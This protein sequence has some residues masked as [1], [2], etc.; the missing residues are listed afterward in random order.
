MGHHTLPTSLLPNTAPP[1][2]AR[3]LFVNIEQ[4][5]QALELERALFVPTRLAFALGELVGLG[6]RFPRCGRAL[7]LRAVVVGRRP[8]RSRGLLSAGVMLRL[9]DPDPDVLALVRQIA[10][11]HVVD[12]QGRLQE[13]VRLP[14]RVYYASREEA[15]DDLADLL[16]GN[17]AALDLCQPFSRGDRLALEVV[18][19]GR[20]ATT[21]AV[22]VRRIQMQDDRV[23]VVVTPLDD[24]ARDAA[25]DLLDDADLA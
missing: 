21:V 22:L 25:D 11:G 12:V 5:A 9:A 18:I 7:E 8:L 20:V 19:D 1:P 6:L 24:T 2:G 3:R 23:R 10:A 4:P 15:C 17:G 16:G 13:R 14:A